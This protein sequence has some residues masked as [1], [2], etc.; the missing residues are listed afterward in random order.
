MANRAC[1]AA[2]HRSHICASRNPPANA[3]PFT[4]AIVGLTIVMFRPNCGRKSGGGTSSE[5]SAISFRSPPAQNAWSPAP[6]ST[7]TKA[8]SSSLNRRA[9]SH[10]PSR[11]AW[12]SALRAS[13]RSIVSQATPSTTS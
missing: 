6:V 3:T 10:K 2:M 11:T 13:G 8:D 12:L 5:V 4:A 7:S 9:P 1:P